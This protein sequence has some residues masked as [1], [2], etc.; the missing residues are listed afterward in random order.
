M[1]SFD[2][3]LLLNKPA[4][5]T[6]HD[7]VNAVRKL[8]QTRKVGHSGTLDPAVSGVLPLCLGKATRLTEFL[9]DL[10]KEYEGELTLGI[11]TDT[12]DAAG[13]VVERVPVTPPPTEGEIR[14]VFQQLEGELW[15]TPP[16][17][18]AVKMKGKRLYEL[19]REGKTVE[20]LP[21]KVTIYRLSLLG[22]DLEREYPTIAFAVVCSK[23]TYVRTLCVEI[24]ERL[25]Y[26]AHMSRLVR[27]K[28]G[29]FSLEGCYSLEEL[30]RRKEEGT[31]GECLLPLDAAVLHLPAVTVNPEQTAAVV[32]GRPFSLRATGDA[33]LQG[34]QLIR[35]YSP[36]G[37]FLAVYRIDDVADTE[38]TAKAVK[39]FAERK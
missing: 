36:R 31:L 4:G 22:A 39:V 30:A 35:V 15:Q 7:C 14:A 6:S 18:S 9:L 28:S 26:P 1:R 34:G 37:E 11:A 25:G 23:G 5:M 13:E 33:H 17:Y 29:P 12:E 21:R 3:I 2:G 20:R 38:R 32:N 19:A 10:P 16:M 27:T 8:F 24:G